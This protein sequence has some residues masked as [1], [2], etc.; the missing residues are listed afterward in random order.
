[1]YR[2]GENVTERYGLIPPSTFHKRVMVKYDPLYIETA[3]VLYI[4]A[5]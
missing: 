2:E 1:M 5:G 4:S 3:I